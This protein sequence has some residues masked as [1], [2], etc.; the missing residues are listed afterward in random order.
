MKDRTRE[1]LFNLL[2][3]LDTNTQVWDLFAGTGAMGLEAMSRGAAEATLIERHIP[4]AQIIEQNVATLQLNDC[5]RVVCADVFRW[6]P[7]ALQTTDETVPQRPWL[8]FCCPPYACYR[9]Q[10]PA[11]RELLTLLQRAAPSESMLVVEA[12]RPFDLTTLLPG[13]W[14]VRDYP[15]AR[16]GILVGR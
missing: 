6:L 10:L 5:V 2:G 11:L 15:P 8:V 16:I 1:A 3:P 14:E 13:D 4:T 7:A 9:E 12:E